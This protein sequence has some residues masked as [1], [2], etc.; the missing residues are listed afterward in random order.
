MAVEVRNGKAFCKQC[1]EDVAVKEKP[2]DSTRAHLSYVLVDDRGHVVAERAPRDAFWQE[3]VYRLHSAE[4]RPIA[5]VAEVTHAGK[6]KRRKGF[7]L[8]GF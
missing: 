5:L 6:G 8:D 1:G 3:A 7:L 4:V 2:G